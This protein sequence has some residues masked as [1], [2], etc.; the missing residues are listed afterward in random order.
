MI[1][2][3][4]TNLDA[5]SQNWMSIDQRRYSPFLASPGGQGYKEPLEYL[6]CVRQSLPIVERGLLK[7]RPERQAVRTCSRFSGVGPSRGLSRIC[8]LARLVF[9]QRQWM[10]P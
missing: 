5:R 3:S 2:V 7:C 9:Y 8:M 10:M 6:G 4:E 1:A